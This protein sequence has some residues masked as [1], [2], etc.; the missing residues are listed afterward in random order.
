MEKGLYGASVEFPINDGGLI[1]EKILSE[2]VRKQIEILG[3]KAPDSVVTKFV[4]SLNEDDL[5]KLDIFLN[6]LGENMVSL[7]IVDEIDLQHE[8]VN[9][10]KDILYSYDLKDIKKSRNKIEELLG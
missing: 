3:K 10:L 2:E 5:A 6:G 4:S 9:A 1:R 8:A 7:N